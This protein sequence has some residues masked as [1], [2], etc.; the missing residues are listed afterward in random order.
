MMQNTN[1]KAR[2]NEDPTKLL[3][4]VLPS[5]V[6]YTRDVLNPSVTIISIGA[7]NTT[8]EEISIPGFE[9]TIPVNNVDPKDPNALTI[10]PS[11]IQEVSLQP[12]DWSFKQVDYGKYRAEP[13]DSAGV[14]PNQSITFQLQRVTINQAA[15]TAN[16]KIKENSGD[17][18]FPEVH[19]PVI[20]DKSSLEIKRFEAVP[21]RVVSEAK[22]TL[23]WETLSAARVT[24]TPGDWPNIKINDSVDVFPGRTTIYTLTAY[25][26]GPNISEQKTIAVDPP[27]IKDF[28]ISAAKVNA[29]DK[30]TI[31]WDV[32][33]AD[34]ITLSPGDG[35]LL[36]AQGTQ[37]V[38]VVAE[39]TY[40]L[41]AVNKGNESVSQSKSVSINP[42]VINSFT[43][44]PGYGVRLGEP[45]ALSWDVNSAVSASVEYS[46]IKSIQKNDLKKGTIEIIPNT[47][48]A[49][50]LIANNSIGM[51]MSSI[52][53]LPMP[54]GWYR[55]TGNAPFKF[56]A[57]P[58]VLKFK[59]KMWAMASSL[60][61]TVYQSFDG[62]NWIP[63][64]Y[65]APWTPL[66]NSAGV[67]FKDKMWVMGGL[68]SG[69][70][71]NA[72][73]S[74]P[75][76]VSW[77]QETAAAQ[78]PVRRSLG[79]FVLP[80]QDKIF[81]VGGFD[82][83]GNCL[84]DVWSSADGKT[85]AKVTEQAFSLGRGAF[86]IATFNNAVWALAGLVNGD[87]KNGTATNDV[88]STT[89]GSQWNLQ[90]RKPNWAERYYPACAGLTTGLYLC[91]GIG[92][93]GKGIPDLNKMAADAV[94]SG[95]QA[96][97]W[98]DIKNTSG[99]EYQDSLWCVGGSLQTGKANTNVWAYSPANTI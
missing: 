45:I 1:K 73:W 54:I 69:G 15:G 81:I 75:D 10:D 13:L 83:G 59:N 40:T 77:T 93:D 27:E 65:S 2:V 86:G 39:T 88:W 72:V 29:L 96:P 58:L 55:F 76:G 26:E 24:L 62:L 9:I 18:S 41:L 5:K 12:L 79:C 48:V 20:K 37:E 19:K 36:P 47:G 97:P 38:E 53:L 60:M 90:T 25:G 16:I 32:L 44:A 95:Q 23:S 14:P 52:E 33:Y 98:Q 46:T 8:D 61:N 70:C 68:G 99:V 66:S 50:S 87:E 51:A 34:K 35:R 94:W 21:V 28:S 82:N 22:S 30:V 63:V 85:W 6:Y 89:N 84:N 56:A 43:A 31:T 92:Q 80:G 64:T 91:G 3:Y 17:G 49:Y 4:T 7:T 67:V 42:V 74:S 78:W 57:A 11:S 71:I